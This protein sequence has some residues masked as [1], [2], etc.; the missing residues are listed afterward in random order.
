MKNA[1]VSPFPPLFHHDKMKIGLDN[2]WW[3]HLSPSKKRL[4][5]PVI[6]DRVGIY[7]ASKALNTNADVH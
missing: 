4:V 3:R 1:S 5:K 7:S 2:E 6:S